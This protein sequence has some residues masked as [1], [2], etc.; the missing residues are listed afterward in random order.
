LSSSE[1]LVIGLAVLLLFGGKRLPE[2]LR[3]W[4]KMMGEIRRTMNQ[5]KRDAGL[6]VI[7]DLRNPGKFVNKKDGDDDKQS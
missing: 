7:D 5:I 1:L 2:L 6:D 4:G 3:T